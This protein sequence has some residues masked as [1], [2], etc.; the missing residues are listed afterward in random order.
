M[1]YIY[2]NVFWLI[3]VL[4]NKCWMGIKECSDIQ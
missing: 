1:E 3:I 4:A 2:D